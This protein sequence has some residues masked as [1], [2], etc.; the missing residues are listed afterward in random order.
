MEIAERFS[1][2]TVVYSLHPN[3]NVRRQVEK[4]L[5]DQDRIRIISPPDYFGFVALM[6]ESYIIITDSVGI[7]EEAPSLRKPVLVARNVTERPAAVESGA[8]LLVGT[9]RKRIVKEAARLLEDP[10]HYA[11]MQVDESPF[12]DGRA[13]TRIVDAIVG[14]LAHREV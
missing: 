14:F 10:T 5:R 8:A 12:G 7:Q 13:S 11:S 6:R 4:I 2:V 1:D 3:P 9:D